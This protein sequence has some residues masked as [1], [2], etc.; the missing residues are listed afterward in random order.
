MD[1]SFLNLFGDDD[2]VLDLKLGGEGNCQSYMDEVLES[3]TVLNSVGGD[4]FERMQPQLI[5]SELVLFRQYVTMITTTNSKM[6]RLKKE[7]KEL[8]V[9]S[10][11]FDCEEEQLEEV[12]LRIIKGEKEFE[13]SQ[14]EFEQCQK[15]YESAAS[16]FHKCILNQHKVPIASFDYLNAVAPLQ[17]YFARE[18]NTREFEQ[19]NGKNV[20]ER[21]G[22]RFRDVFFKAR[23]TVNAPNCT[24]NA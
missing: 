21:C 8:E 4:I 18:Q 16:S 23:C 9:I 22:E 7:R 17:A 14:I 2:D 5:D 12:K 3:G 19:V 20:C 10:H 11:G 24:C 1:L 13:E 6:E 15:L